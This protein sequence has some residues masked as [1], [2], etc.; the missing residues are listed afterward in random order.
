MDITMIGHLSKDFMH[1]I[2]EIQE[3]IGGPVVY[4]S[5]AAVKAGKMVQVITKAAVEEDH[6]LDGMRKLGIDVIRLDTPETTSIRNIYH[7]ADCERRDVILLAQATPFDSTILEKITGNIIHMAGLFRG[8]IPEELI[9]LCAEQG[10]VAVDAQ[11]LLR[12][13]DNGTL[14]FKDW[15]NKLTYLPHI[16]YLKTDAA[17]AEILTGFSDRIKAARKLVSWGAKEVM[18]THNSEVLICVEDEIFTAPFTPE[19]LSGRSGRG[20]TTFAAYLAWRIDHTPQESVSFAAALCSLK[21]EAPGPFSGTL[22]DVFERMA[23]GSRK[24]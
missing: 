11:G 15:E 4:S 23:M 16:K 7:T 8:E 5:A 6:A 24:K 19:N 2:D 17:E 13:N 18:V 21:M 1:Y 22:E 20:D 9:P 10:D 14:T 12:C 3:Y